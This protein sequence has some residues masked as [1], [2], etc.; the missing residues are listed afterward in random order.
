MAW[1]KSLYQN[2]TQFLSVTAKD[3][4]NPSVPPENTQRSLEQKLLSVLDLFLSCGGLGDREQGW[5]AR[6]QLRQDP[7]KGTS[8]DTTDRQY[9]SQ[10]N[11]FVPRFT[12]PCHCALG[13]AHHVKT[14]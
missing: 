6:G 13:F 1:S 4:N 8:L 2:L 14:G 5:R 7:K 9:V 3:H 12:S 10:F 11:L